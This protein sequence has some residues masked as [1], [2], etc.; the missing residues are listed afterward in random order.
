MRLIVIAS[1]QQTES[2]IILSRKQPFSQA[3]L[4]SFRCPSFSVKKT[5]M[6]CKIFSPLFRTTTLFLSSFKRFITSRGV[7]PNACFFLVLCSLST[8]FLSS[9]VSGIYSCFQSLTCA[10]VLLGSHC[11]FSQR[12]ALSHKNKEIFCTINQIKFTTLSLNRSRIWSTSKR[13]CALDY[14]ISRNSHIYACSFIIN[15]GSSLV[16]LLMFMTQTVSL[17]GLHAV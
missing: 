17:S 12:L 6:P 11:E 14:C 15:T 1:F 4:L 5:A 3:Y 2:T 8:T 9:H 7:P 10:F 13:P 16:Y